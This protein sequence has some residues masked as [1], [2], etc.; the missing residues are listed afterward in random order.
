MT[1]TKLSTMQTTGALSDAELVDR[2]RRG[3]EVAF[4]AIME[5]HNQRLYRLA[6]TLLKDDAEA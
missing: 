4:R 3:E 6:R 5:R 2:A 1:R